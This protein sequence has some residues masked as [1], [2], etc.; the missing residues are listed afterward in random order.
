MIPFENYFETGVPSLLIL[1]I[2]TKISNEF[3]SYV[4]EILFQVFFRIT[5]LGLKNFNL[6]RKKK[7]Q[8]PDIVQ[9]Q[10]HQYIILRTYS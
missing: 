4:K 1:H 9:D 8:K 3:Y 5:F 6:R 10:G 2:D 7:E